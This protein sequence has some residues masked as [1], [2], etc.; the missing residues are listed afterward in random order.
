MVGF[1]HD[2]LK[3]VTTQKMAP[4]ACL[5]VICLVII[6]CAE[7]AKCCYRVLCAALVPLFQKE[8]SEPFAEHKGYPWSKVTCTRM[9]G[10]FLFLFSAALEKHGM[11]TLD[12][13]DQE[14]NVLVC[15]E[16]MS[17]MISL[18]GWCQV[19]ICHRSRGWYSV[20]L[21]GTSDTSRKW[22]PFFWCAETIVLTFNSNVPVLFLMRL[23]ASSQQTALRSKDQ[24]DSTSSRSFRGG[25][26][27]R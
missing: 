9:A 13:F 1:H 3:T 16:G 10:F 4:H 7:E 15:K 18:H 25:A 17:S 2:N 22:S 27:S 21:C 11:S 19:T 12:V 26:Y 5:P 6:I 24:N 20:W 14:R 23:K 8:Q